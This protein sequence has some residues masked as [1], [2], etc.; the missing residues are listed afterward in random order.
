M[1]IDSYNVGMDSARTYSSSSTRKL[2]LGYSKQN[3][4]GSLLDMSDNFG[5]EQYRLLDSD[6][7]NHSA[8][9][10]DSTALSDVFGRMQTG[11]SRVHPGEET[12]S[13]RHIDQV[14]QKFVLY[15][16]R[17][18]FGGEKANNMAK[19]L[20]LD[21]EMMEIDSN[22][23]SSMS[24]NSNFTVIT[25]SGFR[26]SY[27]EE[28][29]EL[30]FT[31]SGHV[32][33]ADGRTV[34]FSVDL[35]MSRSFSQYYREEGISVGAMCDPLVLNFEGDVA[36][37]TDQKFFF[38]LDCDGTAE[39]ISTLASGNA[40]LAL[41]TN[42][43]GIINDGSELFGTR[44]GDGFADLAKYDSDGN[45]WID[46]NDSVFDKL[47]VW[48]KNPDGSDELLSLKDKNVGAIYLGNANTDFGLRS[49]ENGNL[50]GRLRKT[51]I[52][53]YED[54]SGVGLMNHLDIAN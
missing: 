4:E 3:F 38:D 29:E 39:E 21:S 35:K 23:N 26:E 10:S 47:K 24:G 17:M 19:E 49:L 8:E 48:V 46:E 14:R 45:G 53:L 22:S 30:S 6:R 50:N 2:A 33:C 20:G 31:S 42:G 44:S 5:G 40:F 28:H 16:W 7:D 43:D 51:G 18:L 15:L 52:F 27:F 1:K 13:L 12:N 32:T 36:D 25:L 41:D 11:R 37:L 34:D 54:G 9:N